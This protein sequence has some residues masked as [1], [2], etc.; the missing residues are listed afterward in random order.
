MFQNSDGSVMIG[1]QTFD[2][3]SDYT[4]P[5][6]D[7]VPPVTLVGVVPPVLIAGP[8]L[9]PAPASPAAP[10]KTAKGAPAPSAGSGITFNAPKMPELYPTPEPAP[11]VEPVDGDTPVLT[12]A[13]VTGGAAGGG[14]TAQEAPAVASGSPQAGRKWVPYAVA[15]AVITGAWALFLVFRDDKKL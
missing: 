11:G 4:P 9:A 12:A 1:G 14:A 8:D 15:L 3:G 2:D 13:P 7:P 10:A 6:Y 5:V